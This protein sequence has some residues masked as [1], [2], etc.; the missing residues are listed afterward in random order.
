M[1]SAILAVMVLYKNRKNG[2]TGFNFAEV[3]IILTA[4]GTLPQLYPQPD[5]MHLWWVAPIFL[6]CVPVMLGAFGSRLT[7]NPRKNL[8]TMFISC[9]IFGLFAAGLFI[10]KPWSEYKL[11]VL[12]G[13]YAHEEKARGLDIFTRIEKDAVVGE[14]S[15][16]C[17]DG[18]YAV[19]G[20]TYLSADQW[21]VNWGFSDNDQP[22]IGLRRVICDKSRDFAISESERL[23]MSLIYFRSNNVNKSIAILSKQGMTK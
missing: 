6:C 2:P 18:V 19:S 8:E 1:C 16:D 3:V 15:F 14:T 23:G 13:T 17:P 21:F 11:G 12:K 9:I 7:G 10:Q 22:D 5:V 20:G 4:F